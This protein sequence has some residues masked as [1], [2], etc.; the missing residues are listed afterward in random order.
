MQLQS[1]LKS[2]LVFTWLRPGEDLAGVS[3]MIC[4]TVALFMSHS[5]FVKSL[6][7]VFHNNPTDTYEALISVKHEIKDLK[8]HFV[9]NLCPEPVYADKHGSLT[10]CF[11]TKLL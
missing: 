1:S 10:I 4:F 5:T 8:P 3:P 6:F 7:E 11:Y 2:H 9:Q